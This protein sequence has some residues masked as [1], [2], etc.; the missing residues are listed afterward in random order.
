MAKPGLDW[1]PVLQGPDITEM[2]PFLHLLKMPK[3]KP[4]I[5]ICSQTYTKYKHTP[6]GTFF[7]Q[8]PGMREMLMPHFTLIGF[9]GG[10]L[11]LFT[12]PQL[13]IRHPCPSTCLNLRW[14]VCE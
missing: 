6:D 14:K 5:S 8:F 3:I 2:G 4:S 13:D 1:R 10:G 7:F 9:A 12:T 11:L